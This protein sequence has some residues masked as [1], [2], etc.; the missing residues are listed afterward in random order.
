MKASDWESQYLEIES[1]IK[2]GAHGK[3]RSLLIHLSIADI[4]RKYKTKFAELSRRAQNPQL[5]LRILND[6]IRSKKM[7]THPA[8]SAE[9]AEYAAALLRV[10]SV[11]EAR[12]LLQSCN[13]HEAPEVDLFHGFCLTMEWRY[14]EAA[15]KF[16]NYLKSPL[17]TAYQRIV[18]QVNLASSL[19]FENQLVEAKELL[20]ELIQTTHA[21]SLQ[22]L[23]ANSLELLLQVHIR[24]QDWSA[25]TETLEKARNAVSGEYKVHHLYLDKWSAVM[26]YERSKNQIYID[27]LYEV[28]DKAHDIKDWETIRDTSFQIARLTQ[29]QNRIEAVY[30]GTPFLPI[31]ERILKLGWKPQP[32]YIRPAIGIDPSAHLKNAHTNLNKTLDAMNLP[33]IKVGSTM[34]R[35]LLGLNIDLFRPPGIGLL[36]HCIYPDQYYDPISSPLRV[37]QV[38]KRLR[39]WIKKQGLDWTLEE[40]EQKYRLQ[41]HAQSPLVVPSD[42]HAYSFQGEDISLLLLRGIFQSNPFSVKEASERSGLSIGA[43]RRILNYGVKND[44]LKIDG[45][46]QYTHY[47]FQ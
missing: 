23:G 21:Q 47:S 14:S 12:Y 20:L 11:T 7:L 44:S 29:D 2:S 28:I 41:I 31:R 42:L 37:Y 9:K 17:P 32:Y 22:V 25:A 46:S 10:G 35:M 27:Q 40:S 8:T 4:P 6:I 3:A 45:S 19:I 26:N 34:H 39:E 1:A 38:I 36:F 15:D 24:N 13:S 5:A 18:A 43:V 30:Y 16:R 33:D